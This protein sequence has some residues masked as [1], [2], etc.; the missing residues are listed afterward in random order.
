MSTP[1][2][3]DGF[4]EHVAHALDH[5]WR[6]ETGAAKRL[7]MASEQ[8]HP[9]LRQHIQAPLKTPFTATLDARIRLRTSQWQVATTEML[10]RLEDDWPALVRRFGLDASIRVASI[11]PPLGDQHDHGRAVSGLRFS[12]GSALIYKPRPVGAEDLLERFTVWLRQHGCPLDLRACRALPRGGY[13]WTEFIGDSPCHD[14]NEAV[15]FYRRQGGFLALFWLLCADDLIEDNVIV[16]RD[17]P[18]W[19]DP[20]CICVPAVACAEAGNAALVE[21]IRDSI[22]ST[23]MVCGRDT[24]APR[25]GTG[26]NRSC[27]QERSAVFTTDNVIRPEYLSSVIS[28]FREMYSWMLETPLLRCLSSGP[29]TWFQGAPVKVILRPTALYASMVDLLACSAEPQKAD[30]VEDIATVLIES[31]AAGPTSTP[32]PEAVVRLELSALG[33]GDIPYWC[34]S[35]N[36]GELRESGS[37]AVVRS[38]IARTGMAR[39]WRRAERMCHEDLARQVWLIESFLGSARSM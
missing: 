2:V 18:I 3:A 14:R 31:M 15:A 19:V 38:L 23:Y 10:A 37:R 4:E 9:L 28:G 25:A 36:S 29:L 7:T 8:L 35:T 30:V 13:G 39:M 27:M 24:V 33:R 22:L 17:H 6:L 16:A 26:L 1:A 21:W 5:V 34:T 12:D 20:E 32:W 11:S